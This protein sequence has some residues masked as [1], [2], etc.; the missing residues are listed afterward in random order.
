MPTDPGGYRSGSRKGLDLTFGTP[1]TDQP[2]TSAAPAGTRGGILLRTLR[3]K[4][5][6]KVISGPSLL[7]DEILRLSGTASIVELVDQEWCGDISAWPIPSANRRTSLRIERAT[8]TSSLKPPSV[9]RSPRIGIDLSHFSTTESLTHPRVVYVSKPYRYFI[10][11][12][13][14]TANGRVQTFL[15]VYN[16]CRASGRNSNNAFGLRRDIIRIGGF[17][18]KVAEKYL[19]DYKDGFKNGSLKA[20]IGARGKGT[21]ST[22]SGCLKLFGTLARLQETESDG[23]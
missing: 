16:A 11:P 15:G 9:Y 17:S 13:L 8:D 2:S 7:A 1:V 4:S 12:Q 18:D 5:D 6:R 10:H 3:R 22:A 20:F 23:Q 14:L 21:S 19:A